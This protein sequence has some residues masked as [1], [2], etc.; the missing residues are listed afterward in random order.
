MSETPAGQNYF[1]EVQRFRQPWLMI[2]V[3]GLAGL[4]WYAFITQILHKKAFGS[5]PAPDAIVWMIWAIASRS[6]G[7]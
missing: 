4:S 1:Y 3:V 2:L 6:A 5:N 7:S